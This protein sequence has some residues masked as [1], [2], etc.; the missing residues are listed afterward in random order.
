MN[1]MS[2][3]IT[4]SPM[5]MSVPEYYIMQVKTGALYCERAASVFATQQLMKAGGLL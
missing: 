1:E 5:G 2:K 4:G 3:R